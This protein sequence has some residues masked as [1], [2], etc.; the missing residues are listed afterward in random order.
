MTLDSMNVLE[1]RLE[2]KTHQLWL[3][4]KLSLTVSVFVVYNTIVD[5]SLV[6]LFKFAKAIFSVRWS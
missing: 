3:A 2:L 5:I 6:V 4:L 1:H